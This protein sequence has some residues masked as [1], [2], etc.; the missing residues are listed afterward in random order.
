MPFTKGF[1]ELL[2]ATKKEYLYKNVP[3]KYRKKYGSKYDSK[4]VKS[5]AFAIANARG[6]KIH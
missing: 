3:S 5:V 1:K 6:I 4:E 2:A